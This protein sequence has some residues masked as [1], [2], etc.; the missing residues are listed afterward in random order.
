METIQYAHRISYYYA[1]GQ[2][3]GKAVV[4]HK[5]DNTLCVN[6][7]H[8]SLGDRDENQKDMANKK[9]SCWGE[10]NP[11]SKLSKKDVINIRKRLSKGE[12]QSTIAKEYGVDPSCICN[13]K[14]K[15]NWRNL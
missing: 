1:T 10:R 2:W 12:K 4:M 5:C 6:P 9:R 14:R 13:I 8:L 15:R 7:S 11:R 3:P